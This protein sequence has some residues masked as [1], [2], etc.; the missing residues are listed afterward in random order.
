MGLGSYY[1]TSPRVSFLSEDYNEWMNKHYIN[2]DDEDEKIIPK[3]F[4]VPYCDEC[5]K[6]REFTNNMFSH[7]RF[8]RILLTCNFLSK[9]S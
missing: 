3:W 6:Q 1:V 2:I 4:Y 7:I 5:E 8:H 9:R